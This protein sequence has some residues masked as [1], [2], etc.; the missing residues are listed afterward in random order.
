MSNPP[1]PPALTEEQWQSWI[2]EGIVY[3]E[4]FHTPNFINKGIGF[5]GVPR[6]VVNVAPMDTESHACAALCLYDQPFGFTHGDVRN[7]CLAQSRSKDPILADHLGEIAAR[8]AAL[9]PPQPE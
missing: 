7:I 6:I 2:Q 1:I 9:L 8:I 5:A 4:R 3:G